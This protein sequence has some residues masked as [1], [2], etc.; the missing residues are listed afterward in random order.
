MKIIDFGV[1]DVAGTDTC[2]SDSAQRITCRT[3]HMSRTAFFSSFFAASLLECERK[4]DAE[5]GKDNK[6]NGFA[7]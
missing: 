5:I 2:C 4:E 6:K 7:I 1:L 3:Y